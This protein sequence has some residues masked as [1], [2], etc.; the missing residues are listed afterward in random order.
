MKPIGPRRNWRSLGLA[1]EYFTS[2]VVYYDMEIYGNDTAC[3]N[4]VNAFMNG[5]VAHLHDHTWA[6][7]PHDMGNLAGVYG[8][9]GNPTTTGCTSG[10]ADY[11]TNPNIPDLI[12]PARWYLPAGVGTYDPKPVSGMSEAVSPPQPG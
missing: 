1:D 4:V 9:T 10:L 8:A 7:P 6:T 12:W 11:L 3:R 5:W 2:S